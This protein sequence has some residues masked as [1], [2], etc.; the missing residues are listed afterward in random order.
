[1]IVI[2]GGKLAKPMR[3]QLDPI[4]ALLVIMAIVMG[5]IMLVHFAQLA[6]PSNSTGVAVQSGGA[7]VSINPSQQPAPTPDDDSQY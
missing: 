2:T 1:M 5:I 4:V 7:S 3:L 6:S